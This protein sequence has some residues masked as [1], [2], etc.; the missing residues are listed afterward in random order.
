MPAARRFESTK[1][2]WP[3]ASPAGAEGVGEVGLLDVHVEQVGQEL[4]VPGRQRLEER[5]ALSTVLTRF[6]S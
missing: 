6:V 5:H 3:I 4:D 2:M 1:W